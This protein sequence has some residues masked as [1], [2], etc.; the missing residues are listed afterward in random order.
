MTRTEV[1]E[2]LRGERK[3]EWQG[4]TAAPFRSCKIC[5]RLP[6]WDLEKLEGAMNSG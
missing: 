4:R 5:S 1:L 2:C 3:I 6:E